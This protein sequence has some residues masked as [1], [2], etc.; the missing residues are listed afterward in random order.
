M[1]SWLLKAKAATSAGIINQQLVPVPHKC[2]FVPAS[3]FKSHF[4]AFTSRIRVMEGN[5]PKTKNKLCTVP[6]WP[7]VKTVSPERLIHWALE[8][9]ES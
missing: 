1:Q 4:S 5:L 8:N 9:V 3:E 6:L 2:T 7:T